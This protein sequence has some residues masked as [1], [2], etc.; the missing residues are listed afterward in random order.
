MD[1]I[2]IGIAAINSTVNTTLATVNLGVD[3]I[4]LVVTGVT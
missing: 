1:A 3:S 2:N 4:A